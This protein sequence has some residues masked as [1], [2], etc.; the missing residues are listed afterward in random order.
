MTSVSAC[1]VNHSIDI[2]S[3]LIFLSANNC[4]HTSLCFPLASS[5]FDWFISHPFYCVIW[6]FYLIIN[7]LTMFSTCPQNVFFAL[8]KTWLFAEDRFLYFPS[9]RWSFSQSDQK[10]PCSQQHCSMLRYR[11]CHTP[12]H[13][14]DLVTVL[15]P[16]HLFFSPY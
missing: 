1:I 8:S 11:K 14:L 3:F 7:K 2:D 10:L 16:L 13:T 5:I 12:L 15:L 4:Y 6:K 9:R